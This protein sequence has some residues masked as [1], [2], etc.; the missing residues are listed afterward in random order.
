[1]PITNVTGAN[2]PD[3]LTMAQTACTQS[4]Q[5]LRNAIKSLKDNSINEEQRKWLNHYFLLGNDNTEIPAEIIQILKTTKRA[6]KHENITVN[7]A[8]YNYVNKNNP[9]VINLARSQ[10]N[11]AHQAIRYLIHEASHLYADTKD[12]SE[13]GYTD[14]AGNYRQPG[15]TKEEALNNADS[16]ACFISSFNGLRL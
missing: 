3:K 8:F 16:Y 15:L 7:I 4:I 6:L 10:F 12:H 1:M 2:I 13:R 5:H 9:N 11:Q 14:N